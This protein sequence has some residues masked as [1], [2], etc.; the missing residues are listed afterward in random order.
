MG[1]R[2][3]LKV[4]QLWPILSSSLKTDGRNKG[5]TTR[6]IERGKH[7]GIVLK[8]KRDYNG[9]KVAERFVRP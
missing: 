4:R 3:T 2:D 9:K 5:Q 6:S 8:T 1:N 7:G